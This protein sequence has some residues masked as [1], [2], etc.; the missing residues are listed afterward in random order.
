MI[1]GPLKTA[2]LSAG[3]SKILY[4]RHIY[5]LLSQTVFSS[6]SIKKAAELLGKDNV[7]SV[8]LSDF[9]SKKA[10]CDLGLYE[11]ACNS[12]S[13]WG[14][15]PFSPPIPITPITDTKVFDFLC[16]EELFEATKAHDYA[17]TVKQ[18]AGIVTPAKAIK[19]LKG[20]LSE[21]QAGKLHLRQD[22]VVNQENQINKCIAELEKS[23]GVLCTS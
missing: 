14:I 3:N 23:L 5:R 11:R 16:H 1:E 9:A 13:I 12:L 8:L 18:I 7:I 10:E 15:K 21:D 2:I 20:I 4:N 22:V 19:V 6:E 17:E